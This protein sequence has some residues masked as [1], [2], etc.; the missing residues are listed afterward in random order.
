MGCVYCATNK[1]NGKKYVGKT[2]GLLFD[3]KMIHYYDTRN[4]SKLY[5]HNAIRKYGEDAFEWEILFESDNDEILLKE[6]MVEIIC[7]KTKGEF[8]YNCTDGGEGAKGYRHTEESLLRM[9][10]AQ[11]GRIVSE[12]CRKKLSE[13][14]TGKPGTPHTPEIKKLIGDRHRGI[15]KTPEHREK[16][17]DVRKGKSWEEIFGEEKAAEMRQKR[18]D[19]LKKKIEE[20]GP[21]VYTPEQRKNMSDGQRKAWNTRR[22]KKE[23][24]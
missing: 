16:I 14:L 3:R 22:K 1:I 12:S 5:F 15:P 8:G 10:R 11:K 4:G 2:V 7:L 17:R 20:S 19:S 13:L 6:E 18:A 24:V 23:L 9:S 21:I